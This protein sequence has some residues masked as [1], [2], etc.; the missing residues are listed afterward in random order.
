MI[1]HLECNSRLVLRLRHFIRFLGF[2]H[3]DNQHSLLNTMGK[4][5]SALCQ[6]LKCNESSSLKVEI[7]KLVFF[8]LTAASEIDRYIRV[9][10]S[11]DIAFIMERG[12]QTEAIFRFLLRIL[13]YPPKDAG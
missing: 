5:V 7:K 4:K 10:L 3:I 9:S 1:E 13:P 6:L 12:Y 2:P 8:V 11:V